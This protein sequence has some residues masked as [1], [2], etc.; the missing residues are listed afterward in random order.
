MCLVVSLQYLKILSN[1]QILSLFIKYK[2]VQ[3][4]K[5]KNMTNLDCAKVDYMS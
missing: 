1:K 5:N 4:Y 3:L 2:I